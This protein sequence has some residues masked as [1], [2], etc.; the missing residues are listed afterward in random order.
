MKHGIGFFI[1]VL[2]VGAIVGSLLGEILG[3]LVPGGVLH[4]IFS[5]GVTVGVPHFSVNLLAL[6]FG[7]EVSLRVN[8][9]TLIG[10]G[11][12]FYLMRR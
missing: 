1:L 5:R 9:C 10:V 7:L 8:L 3:I 4:S 11:T 6:R 2:G 12:A